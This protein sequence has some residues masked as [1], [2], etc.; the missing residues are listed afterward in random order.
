MPFEKEHQRRSV[1]L[2]NYPYAERGFFFIT[3]CT[4]EKKCVLGRITNYE[5]ALSEVG[6][7]VDGYWRDI[8][9]HFPNVKLDQ[10]TIMPNHLHGIIIISKVLPDE[11]RGTACRAPTVV[12]ADYERFGRPVAGSL[13]TIIRSFKSAVSKRVNELGNTNSPLWQ[14]NYF[15]HVI[16]SEES[17]NKIR[18]YIWENPIHWT[19]DEYHAESRER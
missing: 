2:Q 14:R 8:P 5:I 15:E 11:S 10:F 9:Q 12:D 6:R 17:L 4:H 19:T 13:P 18:N 16:R 7:I 3:I 1:R